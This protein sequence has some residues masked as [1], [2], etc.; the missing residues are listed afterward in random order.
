MKIFHLKSSCI[1]HKNIYFY[2]F[3]HIVI[4]YFFQV[5]I[6]D[7]NQSMELVKEQ[8]KGIRDL[9][10]K[11]ASA[12]IEPIPSPR[13]SETGKSINDIQI[14]LSPCKLIPDSTIVPAQRV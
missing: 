3:I 12:L 9:I 14:N 7:A 10:T 11:N 4:S 5:I 6:V 2:I 13:K 1:L 8:F